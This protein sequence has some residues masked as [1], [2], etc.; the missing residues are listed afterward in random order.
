MQGFL[1]QQYLGQIHR[2]YIPY[3]TK[4]NQYPTGTYRHTKGRT[5][6]RLLLL[7]CDPSVK[8]AAGGLKLLICKTSV[9]MR[10][11]INKITTADRLLI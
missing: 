9:Q 2:I 4:F 8:K 11:T 6:T 7:F 10:H 5:R 1:A 3:D